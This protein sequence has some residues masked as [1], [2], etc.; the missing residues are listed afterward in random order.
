MNTNQNQE[1]EIDLIELAKVLLSR[2][3]AIILATALGIAAAAAFTTLMIKP[4]YKSTSIMYVL[5]KLWIKA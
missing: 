5:T 1:I 2:I 4:I 3:W